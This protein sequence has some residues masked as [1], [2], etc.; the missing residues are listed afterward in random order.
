MTFYEWLAMVPHYHRANPE[1]RAGQTYFNAL[2]ETRPDL[3]HAV[4]ATSID[5]F[6]HNDRIPAFREFVK[7]R[8]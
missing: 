3:S 6:H 4:R 8:W 1:W 7:E 2:H 5:P